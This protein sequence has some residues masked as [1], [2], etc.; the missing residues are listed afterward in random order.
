MISSVKGVIQAIGD[1]YVVIQVAGIGVQVY[2]P[3]S[4]TETVGREGDSVVL[5]T[6]SADLCD[7]PGSRTTDVLWCD[8]SQSTFPV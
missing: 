2:V 1:N 3:G 4:V 7:A 8:P 6:T 5:H